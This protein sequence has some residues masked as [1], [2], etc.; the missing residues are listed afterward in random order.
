MQVQF[1]SAKVIREKYDVSYTSL[2]RW[3]DKGCFAYIKPSTKRLYDRRGVEQF[4]GQRG[5]FTIP[6][7]N[8]QTVCYAR[9][10]SSHQRADLE[11][12]IQQ[13]GFKFPEAQVISDVGSGLNWKRRGFVNLLERVYQEDIGRVVV[14]YRD[15]LCRFGIELV[16]WI[17]KKHDVQLVVLNK[18]DDER[19]Q[20]HRTE[21]LSEDLIAIVNFF[22]ARNNGLRA[23]INRRQRRA[24]LGQRSTDTPLSNSGTE[25]NSEE[26]DGDAAVCL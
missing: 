17:F 11:R 4:L 19:P 5:C 12:Q 7:H 8:R 3:S 13:L 24:L 20:Q 26:M 16:E 18:I 2:R 6:A 23:G 9:V 1:I 25:G 15:R 22:V 21:E 14:A 10:S